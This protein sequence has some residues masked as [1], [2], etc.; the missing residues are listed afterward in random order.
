MLTKIIFVSNI[1]WHNLCKL[2][3]WN[4]IG[5][6]DL[7]I[8]KFINQLIFSNVHVKSINTDLKDL[9]KFILI[10][11]MNDRA[12]VYNILKN[13]QRYFK[14]CFKFYQFYPPTPF[15]SNFLQLKK[16]QPGNLENL[17]KK[18]MAGNIYN[19]P[20]THICKECGYVKINVLSLD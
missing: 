6:L 11:S 19:D 20:Q 1:I 8:W 15:F 12:L 18:R 9:T 2:K 13:N 5:C 3:K 10:L 7:L 14:F 4:L 17:S 16:I